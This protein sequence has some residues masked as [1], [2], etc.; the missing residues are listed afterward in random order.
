[1][2]PE[3]LYVFSNTNYSH[4]TMCGWMFGLDCVHTELD[5]WTVEIPGGKPEPN[6]PEPV[7]PTPSVKKIL[8]LSDLHVDLLYDEGSAAVCDHPYC[9][10][11]AFGAK[12]HNIT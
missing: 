3:V 1:M 12:G 5:S 7:Q 11:N 8:H 2:Q 9:C 10:R 4:D 6:H